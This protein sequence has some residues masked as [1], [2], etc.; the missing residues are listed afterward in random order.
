MTGACAF[1]MSAEYAKDYLTVYTSRDKGAALSHLAEG[2]AFRAQALLP[3]LQQL[4]RLIRAVRPKATGGRPL[5][6][7]RVS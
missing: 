2:A 1:T 7:V 6:C 5:S 3:R 4:G